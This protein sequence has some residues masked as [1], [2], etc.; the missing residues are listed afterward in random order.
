MRCFL[1]ILLPSFYFYAIFER[2]MESTQFSSWVY[3]RTIIFLEHP[4]IKSCN[5]LLNFSFSFSQLLSHLFIAFFNWI[6]KDNW[7]Q[8]YYTRSEMPPASLASESRKEKQ[9]NYHRR[10]II[11][12][13][14]MTDQRDLSS[15]TRLLVSEHSNLL[16]SVCVSRTPTKPTC[17]LHCNYAEWSWDT[18]QAPAPT[19]PHTV[20]N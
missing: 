18:L 6:Q 17:G 19:R 8:H 3:F 13:V 15:S 14:L 20:L 9:Y 16:R 12:A 7:N 11:R 10:I 2:E 1:Q 5:F 4:Q